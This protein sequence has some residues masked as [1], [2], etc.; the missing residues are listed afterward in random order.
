VSI[1]I[2][3]KPG[4]LEFRRCNRHCSPETMVLS[5]RHTARKAVSEFLVRILHSLEA[6]ETLFT[7][8]QNFLQLSLLAETRESLKTL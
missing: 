8:S 3:L 7:D 5:G 6:S 2:L 4:K 1:P